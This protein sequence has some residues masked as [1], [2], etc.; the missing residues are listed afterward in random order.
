MLRQWERSGA[1]LPE[2][3]VRVGVPLS[4]LMW[5][6]WRLSKAQRSRS[7]GKRAARP[8]SKKKTGL[9]PVRVVQLVPAAG[10]ASAE[11][12]IEIVTAAA[13]VRV[14]SGFDSDTLERVLVVLDR[15]EDERC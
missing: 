12:A 9:V 1:K 7:K 6:R 10:V 13:A 8:V 2:F 15:R 5:W 14:R 3:A 11:S 4:T